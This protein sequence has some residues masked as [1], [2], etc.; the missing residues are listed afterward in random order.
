MT[1]ADIVA[2]F[3]SLGIEKNVEIMADYARPEIIYELR[4]KGYNVQDA[5][6][7]VQSG[8]NSVKTFKVY[9]QE[10]EHA[11]KEY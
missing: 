7:S 2:R 6:K 5:D 3:D 10:N 1:S 8:I 4:T 11:R 9:C